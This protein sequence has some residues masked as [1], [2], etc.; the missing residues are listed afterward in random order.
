MLPFWFDLAVEAGTEG[1]R[2]AGGAR[3]IV[4]QCRLLWVFSHARAHGFRDPSR[5][6]LAAAERG[7]R[8]LRDRLF[9]DSSGGYFAAADRDGRPLD[10][11]KVLYGQSFVILA[12][13]E[14]F[15][16]SG[17][18]SALAAA[19]D[20]ARLVLDRFGEFRGPQAEHFR[21]DWS[22]ILSDEP[23]LEPPKPGWTSANFA[24]HWVESLAE[25]AAESPDGGVRRALEDAVETADRRFFDPDA[26]VRP[27]YLDFGGRPFR[28][29]AAPR[30]LAERLLPLLRGPVRVVP[31]GP[32][33]L[34]EYAWLRVKA[35]RILGRVPSWAFFDRTLDAALDSAFDAERGGMRDRAPDDPG[36]RFPNRVWWTQAELLSAL[37][38]AVAG[39]RG[40]RFARALERHLEW[41]RLK[42]T[43]PE[44]GIFRESVRADGSVASASLAHRWKAGYHD[45]RALAKFVEAFE[46]AGR[47]GITLDA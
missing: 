10:D 19:R 33:H 43:D 46:G 30:S 36:P 8:F 12:F 42:Q 26:P 5:D 38:E 22:P 44:T 6:F 23:D 9:D 21:R 1:C 18:A 25:L 47:N 16:A 40:S 32:G 3:H 39:G 14:Y 37:T 20:L 41:L 27:S 34:V 31:V 17:D 15:R 13:V 4:G 7:Y 29:R 24:V 11:R 35:E 45:V 2:L 28:V